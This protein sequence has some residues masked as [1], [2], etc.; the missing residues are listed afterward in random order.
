MKSSDEELLEYKYR[1]LK[2]S[3]DG[4]DGFN[5]Y[6]NSLHLNI[7]SEDM[8]CLYSIMDDYIALYYMEA[9]NRRGY[10]DCKEMILFLYGKYTL[11]LK[12]PILYTGLSNVTKNNSVEI[13]PNVWQFI[14]KRHKQ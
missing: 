9:F 3:T 8:I 13:A 11:E 7:I 4:E 12:M 10:K 1:I 5:E 2:N 14:P 6:L